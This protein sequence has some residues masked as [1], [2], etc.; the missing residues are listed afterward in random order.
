MTRSSIGN[1]R[2][3]WADQNERTAEGEG[4]KPG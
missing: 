4:R 2:K 1:K 3:E